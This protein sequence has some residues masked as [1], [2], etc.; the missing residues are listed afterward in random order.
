MTARV[1]RRA[2]APSDELRALCRRAARGLQGPEGDRGRRRA[3]AHRV[4][5]AAAA[6]ARHDATARSAAR[7]WQTVA[8]GLGGSTPTRSARDTMPVSPWMVDAI[9]PQPGHT[10]LE[11]AAGIGDTGFLAAELIQP[12]GS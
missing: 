4:G 9:A 5:Q 7:R 2:D 10:V 1:V 6:G 12:G 8:A 11:L 3:A